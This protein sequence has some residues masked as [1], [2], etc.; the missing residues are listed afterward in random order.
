MIQE[1]I[2][3]LAIKEIAPRTQA[4]LDHCIKY[5]KEHI[6]K[7]VME[8]GSLRLSSLNLAAIDLKRIQ[9]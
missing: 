7:R 5:A 4:A 9:N 1:S 3:E 8:N 2:R 6:I